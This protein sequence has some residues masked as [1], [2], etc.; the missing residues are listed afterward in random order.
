MAALKYV[1][2]DLGYTLVYMEREKRFQ[3]ILRRCGRHAGL[4]E[5]QIAFHITDKFFMREHRGLLCRRQE[6]YLEYYYKKLV[7]FLK[8]QMDLRGIL[9]ELREPREKERLWIAYDAAVEVLSVLKQ[10]K[11]GTGLI[12]NWDKTARRVLRENALDRMLDKIVISSEV[13]VSK[14]DRRIFELALEHE[15]VEPGECLYVGDNYYDDALG[16]GHAGMSS[17]IINPY[18]RIGIEELENVDVISNIRDL[19]LYLQ[20]I[21]M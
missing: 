6:E 10:K 18:G 13:G 7:G 19:P 12:S 4:A 16:S 17:V 8:I 5:L 1:W 20:H 11:I 21:L 15:G 14:P 2:F 3:D 9:N